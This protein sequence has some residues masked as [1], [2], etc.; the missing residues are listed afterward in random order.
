MVRVPDIYMLKWFFLFAAGGCG[1]FAR[2][3][4]SGYVYQAFGVR[5]P[6]GT[7]IV[8]L[9]GCFIIGVLASFTEKK[10]LMSPELRLFLMVGFLGAFTTF[11]TFILE[12]DNLIKN[13][14]IGISLA[15]IILSVGGGLLLFRFGSLLGSLL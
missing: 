15:N 4:L 12:T 5:F 10:F 9:L 14:Q 2:Y 13:A 11:S 7:L 6:V 3:F 1:T 8:N